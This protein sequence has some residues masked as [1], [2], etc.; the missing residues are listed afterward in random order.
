M[1]LQSCPSSLETDLS[2]H[3]IIIY[4]GELTN[5]YFVLIKY[6]LQKTHQPLY[7]Y[8]LLLHIIYYLVNITASDRMVHT[9]CKINIKHIPLYVFPT[10]SVSSLVIY[11]F[12]VALSEQSSNRKI[13]VEIS[14]S[15]LYL[16]TSHSV[17][18]RDD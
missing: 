18:S 13:M 11:F 2:L 1:I 3:Y 15:V 9:H 5:I 12:I 6:S 16:C 7:L 10:F 4:S 14:P 8:G 17:S